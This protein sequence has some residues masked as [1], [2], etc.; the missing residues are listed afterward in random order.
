M[1]QENFPSNTMNGICLNCRCTF[2]D[3]T[4]KIPLSLE[5]G[6]VTLSDMCTDLLR[7][8]DVQEQGPLLPDTAYPT[9]MCQDCAEAVKSVYNFRLAF[10]MSRDEFTKE[11]LEKNKKNNENDRSQTPMNDNA[12]STRTQTNVSNESE[13]SLSPMEMSV[14]TPKMGGNRKPKPRPLEIPRINVISPFE[15]VSQT[16]D[17]FESTRNTAA[18][19]T[20]S[21]FM[22]TYGNLPSSL[23]PF[24]LNSSAPSTPSKMLS[25]SCLDVPEPLD[26]SK[27]SLFPVESPFKILFSPLLSSMSHFT[28]NFAS[29]DHQFSLDTGPNV[30]NNNIYAATTV[31]SGTSSYTFGELISDPGGGGTVTNGHD[32]NNNNQY[33]VTSPAN[34]NNYAQ[35]NKTTAALVST[36]QINDETMSNYLRENVY[37][38]TPDNIHYLNTHHHNHNQLNV[39]SRVPSPISPV[40]SYADNNTNSTTLTSTPTSFM[41]THFYTTTT[42]P[43]RSVQ[44]NHYHNKS[45]PSPKVSHGSFIYPSAPASASTSTHSVASKHY[46]NNRPGLMKTPPQPVVIE[47]EKQQLTKCPKCDRY[48]ES[49]SLYLDHKLAVHSLDQMSCFLCGTLVLGLTHLAD[50]IRT[51][52][53][54]EREVS[55]N[56]NHHTKMSRFVGP[57]R[58][59]SLQGYSATD[60]NV[61]STKMQRL[62]NESLVKVNHTK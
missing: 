6:S 40:L 1:E 15:T 39:V 37:T 41:P 14:E 34:S 59:H 56:L 10:L 8:G 23:L 53:L 57:K 11:F 4:T 25:T 33:T 27:E 62:E 20:G 47:D 21:T 48:F 29:P 5:L 61:A 26:L 43:N 30:D 60:P 38:S 28:F 44:H 24:T 35:F 32:N 51:I 13:V 2:K 7:Q 22:S 36:S 49:R 54:D 46:N 9:H 12:P 45:T 50:H 3:E 31:S 18:E 55:S 58:K 52:H 19:S 17:N 16:S 42:T